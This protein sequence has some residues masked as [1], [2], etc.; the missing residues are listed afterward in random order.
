MGAVFS[1]ALPA[2]SEFRRGAEQ[3]GS[4]PLGVA[5]VVSAGRATLRQPALAGCRPAPPGSPYPGR[6]DPYL[7]GRGANADRKAR[8]ARSVDVWRLV[9]APDITQGVADLAHGG[10]GPERLA[11]RV[12]QVLR[13]CG[14]PPEVVDPSGD[15]RP[16]AAFAQHGQA[17]RLVPLDR[18]VDAQRLVGLLLGGREPVD[19]DD[20]AL[21]R[22]D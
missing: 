20:H 13:A 22:V 11:Q 21:A 16:V 5:G 18:R 15:F 3:T 14:G 9:D 2:R 12:E 17:L 7:R 10:A 1:R 19:A 8:K 4:G 6:I